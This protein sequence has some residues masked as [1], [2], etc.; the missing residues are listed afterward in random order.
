MP[1]PFASQKNKEARIEI[2]KVHTKNMSL[3]DD[4]DLIGLASKTEYY[5]GADIENLC[6]E[7]A[8][9]TL[10]R[11][12]DLTEVN[13][14][15]FDIAL[16]ETHPT[17]NKKSNEYYSSLANNLRGNVNRKDTDNRDYFS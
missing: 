7:A 8:I 3:A 11:S 1:S 5:V 14:E 6:R 10:R 12:M 15:A 2:F 4:V 13:Q 16:K 17:M 9:M